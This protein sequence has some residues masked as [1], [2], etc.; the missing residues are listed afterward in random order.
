MLNLNR[1]LHPI[2]LIKCNLSFIFL[3]LL[4]LP[5]QLPLPSIL[6]RLVVK[7]DQVPSQQIVP[8]QV[9]TGTFGIENVVV[10]DEGRAASILLITTT[11]HGHK[12]CEIILLLQSNLTL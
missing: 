4:L 1:I 9:F 6:V 8:R 7:D 12:R 11:W 10:D 3:N 5:L 2:P